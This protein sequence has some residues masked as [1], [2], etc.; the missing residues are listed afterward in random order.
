MMNIDLTNSQYSL[1]SLYE[2]AQK[3][4]MDID[5]LKEY[6]FD[7]RG[8]KCATTSC[9]K[10]DQSFDEFVGKN[11]VVA[12]KMGHKILEKYEKASCHPLMKKHV[13]PVVKYI[14]DWMPVFNFMPCTAIILDCCLMPCCWPVWLLNQLCALPWNTFVVTVVLIPFTAVWACVTPTVIA[15]ACCL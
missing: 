11:S 3:L 5:D 13:N 15:F 10:I 7:E 8:L 14:W 4:G 6:G 9:S 1:Q 12:K 2:E